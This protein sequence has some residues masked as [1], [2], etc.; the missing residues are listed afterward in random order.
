MRRAARPE[1]IVTHPTCDDVGR[2][3]V[4]N[5]RVRSRR[6]A[7]SCVPV[8]LMTG[9]TGAARATAYCDDCWQVCVIVLQVKPGPQ[10]GH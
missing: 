4:G 5:W 1:I 6:V 9:H 2:T 8:A 7:S 3:Y 10:G